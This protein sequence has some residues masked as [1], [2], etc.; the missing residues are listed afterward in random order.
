MSA[1]IKPE[2]FEQFWE[3][4]NIELGLLGLLGDRQ[5]DIRNLIIRCVTW[6]SPSHKLYK[7]SVDFHSSLYPKSN[8]Q[9]PI[10]FDLAP[11]LKKRIATEKDKD[12]SKTYFDYM[13]LVLRKFD[14]ILRKLYLEYSRNDEEVQLL[15]I[16][17]QDEF[18]NRVRGLQRS[19]RTLLPELERDIA[20]L[21]ELER[22]LESAKELHNR[23]LQKKNEALVGIYNALMFQLDNC[24]KLQE[25]GFVVYAFNA[26][27]LDELYNFTSNLPLHKG[28]IEYETKENVWHPNIDEFETTYPDVNMALMET[29]EQTWHW[30]TDMGGSLHRYG[31]Y[32]RTVE[33]KT[34][35]E[36]DAFDLF[37]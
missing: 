10:Q 24:T 34:K 14:Y 16:E 27:Q 26:T 2:D 32:S 11:E 5:K 35:I 9:P 6:N 4:H 12:Y 31:V 17:R 19:S 33:N 20:R 23:K 28:Y 8:S 22:D 1:I 7:F 37:E 29:T 3:N 21:P 30:D 25:K 13:S 36:M 18:V 15:E